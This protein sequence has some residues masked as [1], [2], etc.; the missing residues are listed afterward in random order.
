M[1]KIALPL[2]LATLLAAGAAC[3]QGPSD[4]TQGGQQ[5]QQR[6]PEQRFAEFDLNK[7]GIVTKQEFLAAAEQHWN[8]MVQH[9]DTNKDGAISQ[10]EF[11]SAPKGPR[12]GGQQR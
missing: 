4:G 12:K 9:M 3:A 2:A 7:D 10:T 1:R 11:L 8:R 6:T 5:Q